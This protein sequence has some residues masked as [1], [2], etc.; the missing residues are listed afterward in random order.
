MKHSLYASL[1][2]R[3]LLTSLCP[4]SPGG[5]VTPDRNYFELLRARQEAGFHLCVG[6][7]TS[8]KFLPAPLATPSG[9][10]VVGPWLRFNCAIV[11][12][13]AGWAA[14]FKPNLAFYEPFG[15]VGWWVLRETI[16]YINQCY[17][18]IP[19]IG[20]GKRA[21]IGATN[22]NYVDALFDKYG[23]DAATVHAW[24]GMEAMRP[25]LERSDRGIIVVVR[26][27]NPG[28]E[29]FQCE[30]VRI[31]GATYLD[32]PKIVQDAAMPIQLRSS[33]DVHF[34]IPS[35]Q[36][37]AWRIARHWNAVSSN[38]AVVAGATFPA[39]VAAVRAI[40]G[41]DMQILGPGFGKQ[42]AV[43]RDAVR[44]LRNNRGSAF[45]G[46]SSSGISGASLGPD[47]AEAAAREAQKLHELFT[48]YRLEA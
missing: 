21:D 32:M 35:Y 5:S 41:N 20:D 16:A 39:D 48:Q 23:C 8:P 1:R 29:E 9:E 38:C 3:H 7:D 22:L 6:L 28:A 4:I 15:D 11:D 13:T 40:I 33:P 46:N 45:L 34:L 36:R 31:D 17:P 25:F 2:C 26:T 37:M 43:V 10:I 12:A 47:F 44:A 18:H 30:E 24:H 14:A 19:T 27:S 42:A